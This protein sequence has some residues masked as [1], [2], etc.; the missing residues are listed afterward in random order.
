MEA[1]ALLLRLALWEERD[2]RDDRRGTGAA[3]LPEPAFVLLLWAR[4]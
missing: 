2:C 1:L 3:P 4:V